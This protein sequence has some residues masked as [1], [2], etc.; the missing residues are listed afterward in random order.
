MWTFIAFGLVLN[1][2]IFYAS[3]QV[4]YFVK[5]RFKKPAKVDVVFYE[6]YRLV[7]SCIPDSGAC[8][9]TL[10]KY[11]VRFSSPF[12]SV[13]VWPVR[14]NRFILSCVHQCSCYP[15]HRIATF[16]NLD[17][18]WVFQIL[19][20]DLMEVT[21]FPPKRR[22]KSKV[23]I[24]FFRIPQGNTSP[25]HL[26]TISTSSLK[27]ELPTANNSN[28]L[29]GLRNLGNTVMPDLKQIYR[30][31]VK[32]TESTFQAKNLPSGSQKTPWDKNLSEI[33]CFDYLF[34]ISTFF[35][36]FSLPECPAFH[37]ET[38]SPPRRTSYSTNR[39]PASAPL[40]FRLLH[41]HSHRSH[42]EFPTKKNQPLRSSL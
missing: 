32:K 41:P 30:D 23:V 24:Y 18:H 8:V 13:C 2:V 12:Q 4:L 22:Q 28:G 9:S 38:S 26:R 5:N 6:S 34:L 37:P 31:K 16:I 10:L 14:F 40:A 27:K 1:G 25:R 7:N 3:Y 29:S 33:M 19:S 36:E 17:C 39:S 20:E 21:K 42:E 15:Y 11:S 35:F